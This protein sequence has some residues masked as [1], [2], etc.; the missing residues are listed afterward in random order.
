MT[1]PSWGPVRSAAGGLAVLILAVALLGSVAG[2]AGQ[3]GSSAAAA[4]SSPASSSVPAAHRV[5]VG[6]TEWQVDVSPTR[7]LPGRIT[8]VVTNAGATEH[9]LVVRDGGRQW[10]VPA[11]P[12]GRQSRI[13]VHAQAGATL[14]LSSHQP[15][16][17]HPM[18]ASLPVG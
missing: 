12:P 7:A 18:A 9:D 5:R 1:R 11:L 14:Q 13:V 16:Q 15:G 2:C 6:L 10:S 3:P 4:T 8:L 17:L